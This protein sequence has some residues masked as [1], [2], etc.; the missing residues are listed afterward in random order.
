M[1]EHFNKAVIQFGQ[2]ASSYKIAPTRVTAPGTGIELDP[3]DQ[4]PQRIREL[5]DFQRRDFNIPLS[6]PW[7]I[8]SQRLSMS[9]V[10]PTLAEYRQLGII[11]HTLVQHFAFM[12]P[13]DTYIHRKITMALTHH[14]SMLRRDVIASD[15]ANLIAMTDEEGSAFINREFAKVQKLAEGKPP[16]HIRRHV[17]GGHAVG[18]SQ[19]ARDLGLVRHLVEV[20]ETPRREG[21][22]FAD[23]ARHTSFTNHAFRG[24]LRDKLWVDQND[25]QEEVYAFLNDLTNW[26]ADLSTTL[27][28][29][30]LRGG[31]VL[32][33]VAREPLRQIKDLLAWHDRSS[34]GGCIVIPYE[35]KTQ[36]AAVGV[37]NFDIST[38]EVK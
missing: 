33:N 8:T 27:V 36:L 23:L 18:K 25:S 35:L 16:V 3:N 32:M 14:L 20:S 15:I 26:I 21:Y 9:S 28:H 24:E 34:M 17:P 30:M 19:T 1:S 13:G 6:D 31:G 10:G 2:V 37:T 4:K 29:L 7:A 22:S 38:W 11:P 5:L 12:Q